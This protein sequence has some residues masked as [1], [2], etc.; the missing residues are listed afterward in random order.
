MPSMESSRTVKNPDQTPI[1]KAHMSKAEQKRLQWERERGMFCRTATLN[2]Y[3]IL[4][5]LALLSEQQIVMKKLERVMGSN[6]N[7][8]SLER[9]GPCSFHT[10]RST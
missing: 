8:F 6:V 4:A 2:I 10:V 7:L 5:F 9:L 1:P 3:I